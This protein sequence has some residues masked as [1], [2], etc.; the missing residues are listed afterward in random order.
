VSTV[1][2]VADSE[3]TSTAPSD[4]G[5]GGAVFDLVDTLSSRVAGR[6]VKVR[7]KVTPAGLL[8]G[9]I[10]VLVVE[11]RQLPVAS[12]LVDRMVVR[13]EH[14][15]IRPGFPPRLQAAPFGCK[16]VVSQANVDRWTHAMRL[17][18]RLELVPDG[19]VVRTGVGGMA[20]SEVLTELE[21]MGSLLRLRP[22]RASLF[23]MQAPPLSMGLL[24][25]Y[26]P[27]PELPSGARIERIEARY[28]ELA[29]FVTLDEI[30]QPLT[31]DLAS[32][33]RKRFS[34]G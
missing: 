12:L 3:H 34:L 33:I 8:R 22:V 19:V 23:G 31:P 11:A 27:L 6:P 29:V 14:V 2:A 15:R 5:I 25:G 26:L 10:D 21:P 16:A 4:A 7:A 32:R 30:D 9:E 1:E 28:G 24:R 20:M 13:A 18:F 17:P